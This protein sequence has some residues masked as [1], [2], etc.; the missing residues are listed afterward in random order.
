VDE[1]QFRLKD[2]IPLELY[3]RER[4]VSSEVTHREVTEAAD[5]VIDY[6]HDMVYNPCAEVCTM[7][8]NID[9]DEK[10][11]DEALDL[12]EA[13]TKKAVVNEALAEYVRIRR[14]RKIL[15]LAGTVDYYPDYDYKVLRQR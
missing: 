12:G 2:I 9:I 7:N 4:G 1:P 15:D 6:V 8:T 10:L 3:A 14:M 13:K 11:M 5:T